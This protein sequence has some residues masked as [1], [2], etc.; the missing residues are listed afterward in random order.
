LPLLQPGN[1]AISTVNE[2]RDL[3]VIIDNDLKFTAHV[4][5]IVAKAHSRACFI[6]KCY[7]SKDV[8]TL[9]RAFTTNVR[10]LLEYASCVWLPSYCSVVRQIESVQRQFTKHLTGCQQLNYKC[11]LTRL[12]M[13]TLELQCLHSDLVLVYKILFGLVDIIANDFFSLNQSGD[14]TRGHNYKLGILSCQYMP[15]FFH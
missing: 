13:D 2:V 15:T 8:A 14:S 1:N 11:R 5:N 9:K 6:C 3:S 10:P 7:I 4:N 12:S